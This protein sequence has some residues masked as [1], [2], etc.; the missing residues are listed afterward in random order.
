MGTL[1][2]TW[3]EDRQELTI[4]HANGYHTSV[5]A[6][7]IQGQRVCG[8]MTEGENTCLY[9]ANKSNNNSHIVSRVVIYDKLGNYK[10][11]RSLA[12]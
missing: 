2:G 7:P 12:R 9:L 4:H 5:R 3:D 11:S 1:Y 10:G 8:V 6:Y